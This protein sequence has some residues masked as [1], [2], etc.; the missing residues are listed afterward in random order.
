MPW[1]HWIY[2][3]STWLLIVGSAG[4]RPGNQYV[5]PPP[6]AVTVAK[7]LTRNVTEYAEFTGTIRAAA[8]VELKT[9][10][11]GYLQEIRFHDGEL[12]K[13]GD[14]LFVI[15][16]T[17]YEAQLQSAK[18]NLEKAR[19][20][21][22]LEE[23]Q[24]L[25]TEQLVKRSAASK[26]EHDIAFAERAGAV[27]SVSSAEAELRQA[28][29]N[30]GYTE[31]RAPISGRIGRHLVDI[32]NLV[33]A[34]ETLLARIESV[35]PIHAYFNVSEN[36]LLRSMEK[37]KDESATPD[38]Q[39][40]ELGLGDAADFRFQ[41]KLDYREFGVDPSTGTILRRAV[42]NNADQS[43]VPGLFVRV[44]AAVGPRPR[45]SWKSGPSRPIWRYLLV[46]N[47]KVSSNTAR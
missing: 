7:P 28:Q 5:P 35:D 15:D 43:L 12:V 30:L 47:D 38:T 34:E 14:L 16:R 17:P 22:Q 33:K 10:V 9:R 45:C 21:L 2:F 37:A 20:M 46:V 3:G 4:C 1:K 8:S 27:A 24:L 29:L 19:A 32:G 13:E 11:N 26:E 44:R 18:A 31:I 6:P 39:V 25:R 42:F 41:G 40:F 36:A 23:A